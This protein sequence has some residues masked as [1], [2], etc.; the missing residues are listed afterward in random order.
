L[1][2]FSPIGR[3]FAPGIILKI[4]EIAHIFGA[5]FLNEKSHVDINIV[6]MCWA[7]DWAIFSQ[8]HLV[9]LLLE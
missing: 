8:A 2:E 1:G 4:T 9:T 3:L 6:K 7:T 5:T